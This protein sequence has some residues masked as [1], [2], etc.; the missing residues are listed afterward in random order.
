LVT[1]I[2]PAALT[3]AGMTAIN[4]ATTG[5]TATIRFAFPL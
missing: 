1:V 2:E 3:A 4:A 5:S